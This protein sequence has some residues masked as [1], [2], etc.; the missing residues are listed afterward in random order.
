MNAEAQK[1]KQVLSCGR[2]AMWLPLTEADEYVFFFFT[3]VVLHSI[4]VRAVPKE[5][6]QSW[7]AWL[8]VSIDPPVPHAD[9]RFNTQAS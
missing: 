4:A 5:Q 9:T 3:A 7:R 2:R 6:Q 8:E 1:N